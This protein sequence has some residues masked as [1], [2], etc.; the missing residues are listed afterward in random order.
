MRGEGERSRHGGT[1]MRREPCDACPRMHGAIA[2][3]ELGVRPSAPPPRL[4]LGTPRPLN[5]RTP[6]MSTLATTLVHGQLIAVNKLEPS[7]C[8]ATPRQQAAQEQ[9]S[10]RPLLQLLQAR[11]RLIPQP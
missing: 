9:P 2:A 8:F 11:P 6:T 1:R 10:L 3:D 4:L 7:A 5:E